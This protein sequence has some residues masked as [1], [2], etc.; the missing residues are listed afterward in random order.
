M[1]NVNDKKMIIDLAK[2]YDVRAV[3]LF[4]SSLEDGFSEDI[5]LAVKGLD[6]SKFFKLYGELLKY[7]S[8]PVD[9]VDISSKSRFND[10]V[11]KTGMVIYG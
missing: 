6:S 9:L 2:K 10:L 8:K 11:E 1:L 5:D 4:G 7:L 3:I